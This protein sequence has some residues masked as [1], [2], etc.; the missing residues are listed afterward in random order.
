VAAGP[1]ELEAD[2]GYPKQLLVSELRGM[3]AGPLAYLRSRRANRRWDRGNPNTVTTG[4][5][6]APSAAASDPTG[7]PVTWRRTA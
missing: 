7:R 6:T 1:P 2:H 3:P 4:R 5:T